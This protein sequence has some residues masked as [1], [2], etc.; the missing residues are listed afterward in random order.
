MLINIHEDSER[1]SR[2]VEK[3]VL[4]HKPIVQC[5]GGKASTTKL[6]EGDYPTKG[7]INIPSH[8]S[9]LIKSQE[10]FLL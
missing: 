10:S 4:D 2:R 6:F 7:R 5:D 8:S 3:Q 9:N 1:P